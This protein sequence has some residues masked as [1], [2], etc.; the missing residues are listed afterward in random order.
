[1]IKTIKST[2]VNF[3][4]NLFLNLTD[5]FRVEFMYALIVQYQFHIDMITKFDALMQENS[6]AAKSCCCLTKDVSMG[7][8]KMCGIIQTSMNIP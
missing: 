2:I 7:K 3:F 6:D 1:M 8:S 4:L 5:V